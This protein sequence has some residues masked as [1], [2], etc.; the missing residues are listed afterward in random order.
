MRGWVSFVCAL[1]LGLGAGVA[2]QGAPSAGPPATNPPPQT[3]A[4]SSGPGAPGAPPQADTQ[5][6]GFTHVV[7]KLP[8]GDEWANMHGGIFCLPEPTRQWTG[9]AQE[10]KI[11]PYMDVLRA[12]MQAAGFKVDGD[13]DNVFEPT[14]S[15]SELQ[16]AAIISEVHLDFCQRLIGYGNTELTGTA[17]I[18]IEWQLYSTLQKSVRVKVKTH[19]EGH[20]PEVTKGGTTALIMAAFKSS[21]DQ[22]IASDDFRKALAA[23]PSEAN[24]PATPSLETPIDL[25][26][27]LAAKPRP[28]SDTTGSVVVIFAG[29]AMGSAFLVSSD[30]MLITDAHVVGDAKYVKVRWPDGVE[31]LGEVVR[32]DKV[33]DVAIVKTDPRGRPPIS[34]R[35]SPM[36]PGETVFAIGAPLDAKFQSTVTRGVVS[37]YRTF[38][39]ASYI[40]S[41]VSVNPGSSGGPLLDEQGEAVGITEG[42]FQVAGAPSGINLFVPVV[43]ALEFLNAQP[44]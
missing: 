35:H 15:T 31:G 23:T 2:A 12:E 9:G 7:M 30:G 38:E 14:T 39:G 27:A 11:S 20:F 33:R 19:G 21:V 37:A 26:G 17:T 1:G 29:Q 41:D 25:A 24:G 18:D 5:S 42:G 6:F 22:L 13:P 32:S 43:D 40:Q 28:V 16:L 4:A 3:A 10:Q 34:I 8:E 36:Q 44:K